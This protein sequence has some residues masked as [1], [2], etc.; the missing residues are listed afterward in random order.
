M[1]VAIVSPKSQ[2]F[3]RIRQDDSKF[4]FYMGNLPRHHLKIKNKKGLNPQYVGAGKSQ[5]LG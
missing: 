1:F 4:K 5:M 3:R 2:L